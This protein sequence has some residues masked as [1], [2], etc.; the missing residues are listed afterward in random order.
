[1]NI[2]YLDP[3]PVI[4]AQMQCDKH[5]VKMVLE[6]AQMLSTCQHEMWDD[7]IDPPDLLYKPTHK[8]HPCNIWLRETRGNYKWLYEHFIGLA[9]EYT[10]RYGK[11]HLSDKKLRHILKQYPGGLPAGP[12]T[13]PPQCMPDEY[14]TE[15]DTIG[16]YQLFYLMDKSRF[17]K[18]EKGREAPEWYTRDIGLVQN[19]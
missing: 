2:F 6:S 4:A 19:G 18:W 3:D 9:D 1:M 13:I 14:K 8:N 12:F 5:V 17:A 11:V 16:A 15:N 7:I 10:R